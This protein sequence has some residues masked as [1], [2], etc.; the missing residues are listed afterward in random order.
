[1]RIAPR[2]FLLAIGLA[3]SLGAAAGRAG[4]LA[5]FPNLPH[6]APA[7]LLGYLTRPD[8]GFSALLRQSPPLPSFASIATGSSAP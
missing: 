7:K 8:T 1:M 3:S 2:I 4:S 5:E 6:R